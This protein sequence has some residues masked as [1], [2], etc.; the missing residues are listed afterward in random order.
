MLSMG[1]DVKVP[2]GIAASAPYAVRPT[3]Q[4]DMPAPSAQVPLHINGP[5]PGL[6]MSQMLA[7][8]SQGGDGRSSGQKNGG[9]QPDEHMSR[10]LGMLKVASVSFALMAN[11]S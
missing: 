4:R 5:P 10:L 11:F 7:P 9:T 2:S 3:Q 1:V 8:P 6:P